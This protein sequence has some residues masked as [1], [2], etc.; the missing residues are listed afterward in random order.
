[1]SENMRPDSEPHSRCDVSDNG[2]NLVS[3]VVVIKSDL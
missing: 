1:M 3:F 2:G